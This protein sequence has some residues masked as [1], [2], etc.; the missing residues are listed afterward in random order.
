MQDLKLAIKGKLEEAGY[1]Q[2]TMATIVEVIQY[3]LEV[4]LLD[5]KYCDVD[6]ETQRYIRT[7]VGFA[8]YGAFMMSTL[9]K[10]PNFVF[11]PQWWI[12]N[13]KG[14]YSDEWPSANTRE[15]IKPIME[16]FWKGERVDHSFHLPGGTG[17]DAK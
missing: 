14:E 6:G 7:S 15:Q 12:R 17:R 5:T 9:G 2:Y 11:T 8:D 3:C 16:R 4:G 10:D 1:P 13:R